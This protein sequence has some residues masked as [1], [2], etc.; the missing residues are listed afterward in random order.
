[1]RAEPP[2]P[3]IFHVG[4]GPEDSIAIQGPILP[5]FPRG[6]QVLELFR[7]SAQSCHQIVDTHRARSLRCC[8]VRA[9]RLYS[10]KSDQPAGS[11]RASVAITSFDSRKSHTAMSSCGGRLASSSSSRRPWRRLS[12]DCLSRESF[13]VSLWGVGHS[14]ALAARAH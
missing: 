2:F 6:L 1:M 8:D 13:G 5:H 7:C 10:Q 11:V 4:S 3:G 14:G 9:V 12:I